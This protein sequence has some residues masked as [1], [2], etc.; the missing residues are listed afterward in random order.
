MTE[1]VPL[2]SAPMPMD[3]SPDVATYVGVL[4]GTIAALCINEAKYRAYLELLTGEDW[5]DTRIDFQGNVLQELAVSALVKQTGMDRAKATVIVGKRW[6]R[7]NLPVEQVVPKAEPVEH[8]VSPPIERDM[9][10][11]FRAWKQRQVTESESLDS[12]KREPRISNLENENLNSQFS[13]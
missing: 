9:S 5:E 11:R 6:A 8:F 3:M 1:S 13:E 10:E 2:K 4:E 12:Q 7:R